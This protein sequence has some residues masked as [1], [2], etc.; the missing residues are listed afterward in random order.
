M[1]NDLRTTITEILK[2]KTGTRLF[3]NELANTFYN[4]FTTICNNI[5]IP[6]EAV[7]EFSLRTAIELFEQNIWSKDKY[8]EESRKKQEKKG[9]S[10]PPYE[11]YRNRNI[12]IYAAASLQ[13]AI[14]TAIPSFRAK[15]TFPNCVRSF[16]GYPLSGVEDMSTIRYI[17]CVLQ[18][19]K[20]DIAPWNALVGIKEDGI[21]LLLK[22][23]FES[24]I[25]NKRP[26][27]MNLYAMKHEY[28]KL[29]PDEIPI[30]EQ[31]AYKWVHFLPPIV[32]YSITNGLNHITESFKKELLDSI[33]TGS[34]HQRAHISMLHSKTMLY[35]FAIMELIEKIVKKKNYY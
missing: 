18:R 29:Q 15:K 26:D 30:E 3:E 7:E 17:A 23:I 34:K 10:S 5:D 8:E 13:I 12:I 28:M 22:E 35:G 1:E 33:E 6:L 9:K 20:T 25:M 31:V 27:I 24:K 19:S 16:S 32:E 4:I 2:K 14:Q 21:Q 11:K